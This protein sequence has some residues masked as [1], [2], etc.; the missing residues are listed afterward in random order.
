MSG[1]RNNIPDDQL[2]PWSWPTRRW[3]RIYVDF[4]H[5][6]QQLLFIVVDGHSKWPDVRLVQRTTAEETCEVLRS[7][8]ATWGLPEKLISDNGPPFQSKEFATFLKHNGV[9]HKPAPSRHPRSNGQ[10]ERTVLSVKSGLLEQLVD[11]S[12]TS[13][14]LQH[15]V[16]AWLFHYRNTPHSTTKLSPAELFLRRK[17]RTRSVSDAS[18]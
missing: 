3:Q 9:V 2:V 8:F 14:S 4:A 12:T 17:P 13:R 7:Q 11:N 5:F 1:V 6:Q 15:T 16:N 18:G 10:A